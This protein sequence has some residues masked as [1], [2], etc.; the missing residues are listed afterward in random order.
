[1]H[2]LCYVALP[3]NAPK[4]EHALYDFLCEY[5]QPYSKDLEADYHRWRLSET[6]SLKEARSRGFQSVWEFAAYLE[7][8]ASKLEWVEEGHYCELIPYNPNS[9][10]D[11]FILRDVKPASA[12]VS[13]PPYSVVDKRG[14]W[15]SEMDYGNKP[16]LDFEHGALHPDNVLPQ[17][18][19]L[20]YLDGFFTRHA[21]EALAIINLHS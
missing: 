8:Q 13:I 19:W 1:M 21:D 16:I 15:V 14:K 18:L 3:E 11:Y 17:K 4:E 10:W 7:K 9:R 2:S 5:L 12:L 6:D 20:E